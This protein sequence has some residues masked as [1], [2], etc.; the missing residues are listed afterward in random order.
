MN[1]IVQI[2]FWKRLTIFTFCILLASCGRK[3]PPVPPGTLR[4]EAINDLSYTIIPD[5]IELKWGVPVRN[6]DDSPLVRIKGF[7]LLKAEIPH[8]EYCE[9]CP[10]PFGQIIEVPFDAEPKKARKMV[11][12]DRTVRSGMHYIYKVRTVKGWLNVSDTS[13]QVSLAWHVLPSAPSGFIVQLAKS[14][15]YLS[16]QAPSKW[17]DGGPVDKELLYRIYRARK[18]TDKWKILADLVGSTDYLDL[19]TK[20][21]TRYQYKVGA[22]LP[23]HGTEIEGPCTP[24]TPV[25]PADIIPP[26]APVD[27][28][29]VRAPRGIELFWQGKT[30]S[31]ISGYIVYRKG[32]NNLLDKLNNK[33]LPLSRFVDRAILPSGLYTYWVTAIDKADPANESPLSNPAKVEVVEERPNEQ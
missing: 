21:R 8:E 19:S 32:P 24:E 17:T 23:Y 29:A 30:E 1:N 6:R 20:K 13:N 33:P 7:R 31:D 12:E 26:A 18:G 28:V 3:A 11:Y 4:P 10:P 14:G 5:G 25:H 27:L 2:I 9:D 16:W 22:V 15:V